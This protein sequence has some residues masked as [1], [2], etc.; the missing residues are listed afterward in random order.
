MDTTFWGPAGHQLF[1]YLTRHYDMQSSEYHL[2]H[3]RVLCK[4]FKSVGHILPCIYCRRSFQQYYRELPLKPYAKRGKSFEW[5]YKIHNLINAKLRGQGYLNTRDPSL[6]TVKRR[7][8][9]P[10]ICFVGW[11][12][13]YS[14]VYHYPSHFSELSKR[15]LNAYSTFFNLLAVFY[16]VERIRMK[17]SEYLQIHPVEPALVGGMELVKWLYEFE[18]RVNP[19]CCTFQKRCSK[20]EKYKVKKC[21]NKSCRK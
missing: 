14:V 12:F 15:R 19:K 13:L 4:F 17:Y 2:T 21:V 7:F 20:L 5:Y 16:P 18:K 1:H 11:N 6:A 8:S 3:Y 9:H 10:P